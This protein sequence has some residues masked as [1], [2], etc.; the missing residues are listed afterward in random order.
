[1]L[2]TTYAAQAMLTWRRHSGAST[3]SGAYAASPVVNAARSSSV[4]PGGGSNTP[5]GGEREHRI[6]RGERSVRDVGRLQIEEPPAVAVQHGV[7]GAGVRG[8]QHVPGARLQEGAGTRELVLDGGCVRVGHDLDQPGQTLQQLRPHAKAGGAAGQVAP[9]TKASL[10]DDGARTAQHRAEIVAHPRAPAQA[11]F[12][13]LTR[14]QVDQLEAQFVDRLDGGV[15]AQ[16]GRSA[17]PV[18]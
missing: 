18:A 12:G 8:P 4:R 3:T 17:A 5:A 2:S 14:Q 10:G 11:G 16:E 7:V 1:M 15:G 6:C 13:V 9:E